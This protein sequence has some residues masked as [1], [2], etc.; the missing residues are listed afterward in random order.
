VRRGWVIVCRGERRGRNPKPI[1]MS[2]F[3]TG[4]TM[5]EGQVCLSRGNADRTTRKATF[6][7]SYNGYQQGITFDSHRWDSE[8]ARPRRS[9]GNSS[10]AVRTDQ[11]RPPRRGHGSAPCRHYASGSLGNA[12]CR[13][14]SG[15]DLQIRDA[16]RGERL[17]WKPRELAIPH[18]QVARVSIAARATPPG[19]DNRICGR[20][21]VA[22]R[23]EG[24][25]RVLFA[26]RV[27]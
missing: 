22:G 24:I 9:Q 4:E 11:W 8:F 27:L 20:R 25:M 21:F 15:F 7:R 3:Q 6:A 5:A 13:G 19:F 16:P 1:Q 2:K 18:W 26:F 17:Y 10:F 14:G 23:R 12:T